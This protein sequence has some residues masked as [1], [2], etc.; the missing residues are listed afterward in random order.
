VDFE[1]CFLGKINFDS[2]KINLY[3]THKNIFA[4]QAQAQGQISMFSGARSVGSLIFSYTGGAILEIV[5]HRT[6]TNLNPFY[7]C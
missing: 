6:S 7:S 1:I 3:V 5:T 2:L 4:R